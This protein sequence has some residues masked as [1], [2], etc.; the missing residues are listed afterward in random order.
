[1]STRL[2]VP[3]LLVITLCTLLSCAST[4]V[5]PAPGPRPSGMS[6][7]GVWFSPQFEDM[8]LR[9]SGEQL[10]GIYTYKYGGTIEGI[11]SGNLMTFTWIEPGSRKGARRELRGQGYLQMVAV[12]DEIKLVGEWGY[13]EDPVGG[14]PWEAEFVRKR[15]DEDPRDL[16]DLP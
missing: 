4:P 10:N 1:M 9:Q 7:D 15:E 6:F 12:G 2:S 3:A 13:G 16:K 8:Y 11:V 5:I 14:G